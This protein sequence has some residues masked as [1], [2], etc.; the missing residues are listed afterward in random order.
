MP[1]EKNLLPDAGSLP[2]KARARKPILFLLVWLAAAIVVALLSFFL[3]ATFFGTREINGQSMEPTVRDGDT[4]VFLKTK[5]VKCGDVIIFSAASGSDGAEGSSFDYI[6]RVIGKPG[7][8]VS[9]RKESDGYLHVYRN[10]VRV[11]EDTICEPFRDG[12]NAERTVADGQLYVLGD[13]RNRSYDSY[14]GLYAPIDRVC[15]KA[16]LRISRD[17]KISLVK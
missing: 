15:G 10:G 17:K 9:V 12:D 1:E 2:P 6:K 14:D 3:T 11:S 5:K 16:F 13:N 8:V 7:D 4:V